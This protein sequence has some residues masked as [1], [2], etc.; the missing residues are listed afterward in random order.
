MESEWEWLLDTKRS[1]GLLI[2]WFLYMYY[3]HGLRVG[4]ATGHREVLWAVDWQVSM[5]DA[6]G[7]FVHSRR[8]GHS[9]LAI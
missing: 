8:E 9:N 3:R 4:V 6:G 1:F 2:S 7:Q 5:W